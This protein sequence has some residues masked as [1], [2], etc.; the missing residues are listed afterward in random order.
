MDLVKLITVVTED[1]FSLINFGFT[2][3]VMLGIQ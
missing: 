3:A 1:V 2:C